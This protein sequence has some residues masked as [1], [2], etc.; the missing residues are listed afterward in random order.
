MPGSAL[1]ADGRRA[2]RAAETVKALAH[3]LRL[4]ILAILCEADEHVTDLA[5][6]LEVPQSVV[7]QQ[8]RVLRMHGL[9]QAARSRG[10]AY[11]HLREPRVADLIGCLEGCTAGGN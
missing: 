1:R 3:P 4:R 6:E 2:Q 10:H 9:V 8:L 7:S 11:Y 5:E